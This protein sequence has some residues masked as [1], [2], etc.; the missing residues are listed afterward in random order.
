MHQVVLVVYYLFWAKC[1]P[2]KEFS[3]KM[4]WLET[5]N[6]LFSPITKPQPLNPLTLG[7]SPLYWPGY[8]LVVLQPLCAYYTIFV[9]FRSHVVSTIAN[10]PCS[11]LLCV[12]SARSY[13]LQKMA[14]T[15]GFVLFLFI[16]SWACVFAW[17]KFLPNQFVGLL[18]SFIISS[19]LHNPLA[20]TLYLL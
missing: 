5:Q 17:H 12:S 1:H 9:F 20:C 2:N 13:P 18:L 10:Y 7:P 11:I 19:G 4:L 14:W 15:F 8:K 6:R 16:P 3:Q